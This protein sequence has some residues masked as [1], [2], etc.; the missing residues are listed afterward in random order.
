MSYGNKKYW[1]RN[2][3]YLRNVSSGLVGEVR[4]MGKDGSLV[5]STKEWVSI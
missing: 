2:I 3:M 1:K 4:G 5:V